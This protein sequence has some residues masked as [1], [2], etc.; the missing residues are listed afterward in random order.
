MEVH[1]HPK[2]ER[3][4]FKEYFLEFLMIFLAVT[5][6][7][8]AENIREHFSDHAHARQL[9]GQLIEALKQDTI[10]LNRNIELQK[11]LMEN[12]DILFTLLQEPMEKVD[13]GKVQLYIDSCYRTTYFTPS[14]GAITAIKNSL[15]LKPFA[16]SRIITYLTHY[17]EELAG[18]K[19]IENYQ[20]QGLKEYL[21]TFIDKHFTP[22]NVRSIL[23]NDSVTENKLRN[24]TSADLSQLAVDISIVETYQGTL[25]HHYERIKD[26]AMTFIQYLRDEYKL[27]E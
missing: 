7:F 22:V 18:T 14:S 17:E 1:H 4:G 19:A 20:I 8:L 26:S 23:F 6:G 10:N 13:F 15:Q 21:E 11:R 5:L 25:K 2:V 24:V 12:A 16:Q 9:T 27:K 3:K